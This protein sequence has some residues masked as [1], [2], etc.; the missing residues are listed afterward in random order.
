MDQLGKLMAA[1]DSSFVISANVGQTTPGGTG[2][3]KLSTWDWVR[4]DE[5]YWLAMVL[6]RD[7]F[8]PDKEIVNTT[9]KERE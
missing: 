7:C 1:K 5:L 8:H 2:L 4:D 6:L 3:S 9:E